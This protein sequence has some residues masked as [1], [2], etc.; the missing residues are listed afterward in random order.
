MF[1]TKTVT[2][3][4]VNNI[5]LYINVIIKEKKCRAINNVYYGVTQYKSVKIIYNI[6]KTWSTIVCGKCEKSF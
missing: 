6:I 1:N 5:L 3:D 2:R 4:R